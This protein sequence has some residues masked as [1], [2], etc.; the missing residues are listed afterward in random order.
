MPGER[1][2]RRGDVMNLFQKLLDEKYAE[3][4]ARGL[5]KARWEGRRETIRT[6][7]HARFGTIPPAVAERITTADEP[8]LE[9]LLKQAATAERLEDL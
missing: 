3:G 8:T 7:I 6:V 5:K 1:R 9:T 2:P 4:F